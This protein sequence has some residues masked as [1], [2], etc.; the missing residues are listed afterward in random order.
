MIMRL[1]IGAALGV[2]VLLI[3]VGCA[4]ANARSTQPQEV[5]VTVGAPT[6]F[7]IQASTTTFKVGVP[8]RFAVTNKGS[9]EHEVMLMPV[10]APGSMNMTEMDKMALG[11]VE[12][13]DLPPGGHAS[14]EV[15]F[16]D[17]DTNKHLEIACHLP[18]HYEAGMHIP[19][20]VVER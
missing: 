3:S 16:K 20:T 17:G 4:G 6:E 2:V 14:F 15:T 5:A 12:K 11:M 18:G 8:Y 1:V 9:A 7:S 10:V 19:I 13:E